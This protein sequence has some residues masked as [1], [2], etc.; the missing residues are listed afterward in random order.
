MNEATSNMQG[1]EQ[2]TINV[3]EILH[4]LLSH[5]LWIVLVVAVCVG[6][7]FCYTEFMTTPYYKSTVSLYVISAGNNTAGDVTVATYSARDCVGML[8]RRPAM[9][10]VIARLGLNMTYEQL[11]AKTAILYEDE[12][13]I[14]DIVITDADPD[15]AKLLADTFA[16]VAKAKMENLMGVDRAN[17]DPANMPLSPAGPSL[18]KNVVLAAVVGFAAVCLFFIVLY[19]LDDKVKNED[20]I[21]KELGL[22]VLGVIPM[23]EPTRKKGGTAV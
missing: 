20:H 8:Q 12:S 21:E 1:A 13:R 16:E 17:Y 22:S 15:R 2:R 5:A 23:E 7:A 18:M 4:Y 19:V 9:E 14:I 11:S 6:G 3:G 10:E